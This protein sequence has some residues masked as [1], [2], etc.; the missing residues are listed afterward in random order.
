M[1]ARGR[2]ADQRPR[3]WKRHAQAAFGRF[4][5]GRM[6]RW[7]RSRMEP[8]MPLRSAGSRLSPAATPRSIH[9]QSRCDFSW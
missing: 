7:R 8:A 5:N 3:A 9:G 1:P 2:Q 4:R 6:S